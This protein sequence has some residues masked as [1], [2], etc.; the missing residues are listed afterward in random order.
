[1]RYPD[2]FGGVWSTAPDPVDFRDFQRINLYS[3]GVNMFTDEAGRP[4]PLARRGELPR[5]YY[6]PFS[7][8]EVVA[9]HGGQLSRSEAVF[10]ARGEGGIPS[11]LWDRNRQSR[12]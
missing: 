9:G 1:M 2:I 11:K 5:V 3:P 4:R 8:M 7:D 6:K 12:S 10:G